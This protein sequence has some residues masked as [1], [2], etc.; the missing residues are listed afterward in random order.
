MH[1]ILPYT[2]TCALFK[3]FTCIAVTITCFNLCVISYLNLSHSSCEHN[4]HVLCYLCALWIHLQFHHHHTLVLCYQIKKKN[5]SR[6]KVLNFQKYTLAGHTPKCQNCAGK[7]HQRQSCNEFLEP[8]LFAYPVSRQQCVEISYQG[9]PTTFHPTDSR[10]SESWKKAVGSPLLW[11]WALRNDHSSPVKGR[12]V[13]TPAAHSKDPRA[14][15]QM[16][17]SYSANI[18]SHQTSCQEGLYRH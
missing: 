8:Q 7:N 16:F 9:M 2:S 18:C 10:C 6:Y 13:G 3:I 4:M 11:I 5:F 17:H 15:E 12:P 1:W 14:A